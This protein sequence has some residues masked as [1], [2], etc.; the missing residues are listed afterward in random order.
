[1]TTTSVD[2]TLY[3]DTA[4]TQ[5]LDF[6]SDDISLPVVQE[7]LDRC[8]DVALDLV[9]VEIDASERGPNGWPLV[10]FTATIET[11]ITILETYEDAEC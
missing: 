1:M 6:A 10:R 3:I 4:T 7:W 11:L 2:L 8:C 9:T 5:W